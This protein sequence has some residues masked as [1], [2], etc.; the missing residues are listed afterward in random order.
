MTQRHPDHYDLRFRRTQ[1][2]GWRHIPFEDDL[3]QPRGDMAVLCGC[4]F[5]ALVCIITV[6]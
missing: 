6:L 4:L 3:P 2:P 1:P 5:V